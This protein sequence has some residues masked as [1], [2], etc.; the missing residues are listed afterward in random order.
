MEGYKKSTVTLLLLICC[1]CQVQKQPHSTQ[2]EN[3][4]SNQQISITMDATSFTLPSLKYKTDT[5]SNNPFDANAKE[6]I[7][8]YDGAFSCLVNDRKELNSFH[9]QSKAYV[10]FE[11]ER[12]ELVQNGAVIKKIIHP[13]DFNAS[14][15]QQQFVL[16]TNEENIYYFTNNDEV[17]STTSFEVAVQGKSYGGLSSIVWDNYKTCKEYAQRYSQET[18]KVILVSQILSISDRH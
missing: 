12:L 5:R 17:I 16:F 4:K 13:K 1:A 15:K 10:V 3:A 6:N 11:L 2:S 18:G 7:F 9:D 14:N 8:F